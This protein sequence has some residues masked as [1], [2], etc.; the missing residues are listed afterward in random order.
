MFVTGSQREWER[1]EG[2]T[3][4]IGR[5]LLCRAACSS[6]PDVTRHSLQQS[7]PRCDLWCGIPKEKGEEG[8]KTAWDG[9]AMTS[10][11]SESQPAVQCDQ[12]R[13]HGKLQGLEYLGIWVSCENE[14]RNAGPALSGAL[15]PNPSHSFSST[16][17]TKNPIDTP[18]CSCTSDFARS[19]EPRRQILLR[20]SLFMKYVSSYVSLRCPLL[21]HCS[22]APWAV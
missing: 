2:D 6:C 9:Y 11:L 7:T 18:S 5:V 3:S 17:V 19:P 16:I 4:P 14:F 12:S 22:A 15:Q 1:D 13:L 21:V 20:A 8:T 10:H